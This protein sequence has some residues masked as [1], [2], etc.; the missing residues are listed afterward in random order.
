MRC[1]VMLLLL[2]R[3]CCFSFSK[4]KDPLKK[5]A[6]GQQKIRGNTALLAPQ[7]DR[8]TTTYMYHD[9]IN[10]IFLHT[11]NKEIEC[12]ILRNKLENEILA[13]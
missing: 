10:N 4:K 3:T 2:C 13:G 9:I 11:T 5:Y 8:R 1:F 12:I 6:Y 7:A